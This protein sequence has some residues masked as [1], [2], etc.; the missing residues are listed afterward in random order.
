LQVF[1][2]V[3]PVAT[4]VKIYHLVITNEFSSNHLILIGIFCM[5]LIIGAI[6]ALDLLT[7]KLN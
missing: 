3:M 1:L 2:L 5:P 4:L 7:D 6:I